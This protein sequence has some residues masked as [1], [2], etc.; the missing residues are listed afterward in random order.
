MKSSWTSLT[1]KKSRR[2]SETS[3][4]SELPDTFSAIHLHS[5]EL[6]SDV[7]TS[8]SAVLPEEFHIKSEKH[9]IV[10]DLRNRNERNA[11]D[12]RVYKGILIMV[13]N[14]NFVSHKD[15]Y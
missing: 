9:R 7:H 11:H 13:A 6:R 10:L 14:H 5:R 15:N 12:L 4:A 2:K 8:N 3:E 1:R